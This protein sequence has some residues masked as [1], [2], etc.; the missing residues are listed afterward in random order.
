M[1][2]KFNFFL[3]QNSTFIIKLAMAILMKKRGWY[4][5]EE[6]KKTILNLW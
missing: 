6:E 1:M 5:E 2:E 3:V 4:Q